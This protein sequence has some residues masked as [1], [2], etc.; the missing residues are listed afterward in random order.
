MKIE[1]GEKKGEN[2]EMKLKRWNEF[3]TD[4]HRSPVNAKCSHWVRLQEVCYNNMP[5]LL[6]TPVCDFVLT[7]TAQKQYELVCVY[8]N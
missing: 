8:L 1:M 5:V 7:C 3:V 6:F 4:D 2:K